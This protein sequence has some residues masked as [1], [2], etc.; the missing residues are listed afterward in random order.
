VDWTLAALSFVLGCIFILCIDLATDALRR[1]RL[2]LLLPQ[3]EWRVGASLGAAC[4]AHPSLPGVRLLPGDAAWLG[5]HSCTVDLHEVQR[6]E[7]I[8]QLQRDLGVIERKH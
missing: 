1:R 7:W 8:E 6:R 4:R 5:H 3:S 2:V